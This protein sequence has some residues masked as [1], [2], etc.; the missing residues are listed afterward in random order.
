MVLQYLNVCVLVLN[1]VFIVQSLLYFFYLPCLYTFYF[2]VPY[3]YLFLV[4]FPF[5]FES[6]FLSEPH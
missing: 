4:P 3:F 6:F 5:P 2:L 1:P